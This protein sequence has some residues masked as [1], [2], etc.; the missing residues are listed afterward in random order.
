MAANLTGDN[1]MNLARTYAAAEKAAKNDPTAAN[2]QAACIALADLIAVPS[3]S[4]KAIAT[5]LRVIGGAER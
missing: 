1:L 4:Q 5:A 2:V 3:L